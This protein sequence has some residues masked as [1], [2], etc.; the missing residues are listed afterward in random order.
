MR[1]E[2]GSSDEVLTPL[3]PAVQRIFNFPG[4]LSPH[5]QVV[6]QAGRIMQ[7]N[8]QQGTKRKVFMGVYRCGSPQYPCWEVRGCRL[9]FRC[10]SPMSHSR[11]IRETTAS[12][13]YR[14]PRCSHT[15]RW[16]W[17]PYTSPAYR[18]LDTAGHTD[19]CNKVSDEHCQY[20]DR[21]CR[22]VD[23]LNGRPLPV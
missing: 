2:D 13:A 9:L 10:N 22:D 15:G 11:H 23:L 19:L 8:R 14:T 5:H 4:Y 16:S 7:K 21:L 3:G 20:D 12:S 18:L 17:D 1:V 6:Y